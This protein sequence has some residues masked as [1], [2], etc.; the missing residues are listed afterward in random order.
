LLAAARAIRGTGFVHVTAKLVP[1]A[2]L[3]E[4]RVATRHFA[5][6]FSGERIATRVAANPFAIFADR[7][8]AVLSPWA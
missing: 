8:D 7:F 5:L 4:E 3:T 6:L 2:V 1:A